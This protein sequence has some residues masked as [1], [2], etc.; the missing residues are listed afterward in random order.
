MI[1]TQVR[2]VHSFKLCDRQTW[3]NKNDKLV[4]WQFREG[5]WFESCQYGLLHFLQNMKLD[6]ESSYYYNIV[7]QRA[8]REV[9]AAWR[10]P[11]QNLGGMR[12]SSILVLAILGASSANRI[13]SLTRRRLSRC[14][15]I[16]GVQS[17]DGYDL[18][19]NLP[20]PL[21]H[22]VSSE[23]ELVRVSV[24]CVSTDYWVCCEFLPSASVL[25]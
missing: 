15:E 7:E 25:I 18:E 10:W 19:Q 14:E 11:I 12:V 2:Q 3:G 20:R 13:K 16:C 5:A 23:D 1:F 6:T 8:R 4:D 17:R 24:F 21:H 22:Q 9:D